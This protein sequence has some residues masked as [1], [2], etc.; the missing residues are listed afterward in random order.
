AVSDREIAQGNAST[1]DVAP[2]GPGRLPVAASAHSLRWSIAPV[3]PVVPRASP[4]ERT[5]GPRRRS[6]QGPALR[7]APDLPGTLHATCQR[8]ASIATNVPVMP[9]ALGTVIVK[10]NV[11]RLVLATSAAIRSVRT[12]SIIWIPLSVSSI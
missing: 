2:L 4:V 9:T 3:L 6:P 8:M 11:P 1:S 5:Q 12:F 7:G 10:K